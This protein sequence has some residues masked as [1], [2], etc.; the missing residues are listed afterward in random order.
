M[1]SSVIAAAAGWPLGSTSGPIKS[2]GST[3]LLSSKTAY[4]KPIL[5]PNFELTWVYRKK[6]FMPYNGFKHNHEGSMG[7]FSV[8][9][10]CLF[11]LAAASLTAET[12]LLAF[13][14]STRKESYNQ[15]LIEEAAALAQQMGAKVTVI[16]LSDYPMP[17]YDADLE[18]E[19]GLPK[20]AQRLRNAMI[21]SDAI[22][23]A[24]P[25]YNQSVSGVLKNAIDWASRGEDGEYSRTAFSGKAFG[26]MSA[27]PSKKGGKRGL[28]H[29]RTILEDAGGTVITEQVT[30]PTAYA[31]FA[32]KE[33]PENPQLRMELQ[34]LLKPSVAQ[35]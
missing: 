25:E 10:S 31:Y 20:N 1:E 16:H 19:K 7:K 4:K 21:E 9:F 15:Q 30:I 8:F 32:D 17:F 2:K 23:I 35:K 34:K 14:G 27:S 33:R 24:S 28:T 26:I 22:L 6:Y 29:L 11:L 12:K 3:I 5:Y 18:A 13:S